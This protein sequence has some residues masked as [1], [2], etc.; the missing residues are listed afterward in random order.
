VKSASSN[1][2]DQPANGVTAG[3]DWA[4]EDHTVAVVDGGG[5]EIGRRTIEHSAAGLR[6]LVGL[7]RRYRV[8]EIAIERPDG[9]LVETL[10]E[11]GITVVVI[12]P[13]QVKD[14][15]GR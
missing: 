12:S 15:R 11:A 13:N 8:E 5:R 10:L 2:P 14:L 3:V 7:L 6:D 4:W 9:P 1:L